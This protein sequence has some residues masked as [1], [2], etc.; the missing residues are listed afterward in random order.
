ME[1]KKFEPLKIL[2][3]PVAVYMFV[4][5]NMFS[6]GNSTVLNLLSNLVILIAAY[7]G[8]FLV[9]FLAVYISSA[10]W[11]KYNSWTKKAKVITWIAA[12]L[13]ATLLVTF[14]F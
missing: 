12:A 8:A 6:V 3:A 4:R 14:G 11:D 13:A 2:A 9:L 1:T 7:L 10:V 5:E